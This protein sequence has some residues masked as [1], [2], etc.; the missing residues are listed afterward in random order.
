MKNFYLHCK[1]PHR[2]AKRIHSCNYKK[3]DK[4]VYNWFVLRKSQKI[5]IDGALTKEEAPFHVESLKF[6]YFKASDG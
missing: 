2:L 4:A 5:P 3:V 6:P 1:K